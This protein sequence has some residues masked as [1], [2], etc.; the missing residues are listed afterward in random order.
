MIKNRDTYSV[1]IILDKKSYETYKTILIYNISC[2]TSTV[3]KQWHIKFD[4][5]YGFI[6]VLVGEIKHLVLSDYGLF[7]KICDRIKYLRSEKI[8][9]TDNSLP[10]EKIFIFH[11]FIIHI[12]SV[13]NKNKNEYCYNLFLEKGF[14]KNK[15]KARYF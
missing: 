2:K 15:Y 6:K 14:Y 10:I 4:K 9:I 13:F 11:N 8:G 5:V 1:D 3:P 7:E 12:K